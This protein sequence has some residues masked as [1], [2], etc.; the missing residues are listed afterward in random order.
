MLVQTNTDVF[1]EK[2]PEVIR[3]NI[4]PMGE[5]VHLGGG[6]SQVELVTAS[7]FVWQSV[8][9]HIVCMGIVFTISYLP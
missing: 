5:S 7:N 1:R 2:V 9:P 6:E 4:K 3:K 8:E